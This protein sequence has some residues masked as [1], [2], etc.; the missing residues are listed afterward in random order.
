MRSLKSSLFLALLLAP[1]PLFAD[2][3]NWRGPTYDGVA[4]EKGVLPK[5]VVG[6]RVAWKKSLGTGYSSVAIASGKAVT[7]FGDGTNDYVVA[8]DLASGREL[9]RYRADLTYKGGLAGSGS[10]DGASGTPSIEGGVV[11]ALA[12]MGQLLALDLATGKLL[13]SRRVDQEDAAKPPGA[14]F[15]TSPTIAG[16]IVVVQTGGAAGHG[17]TGYDKL[18]GARLWSRG[19]DPVGYQSP[20]LATIDGKRQLVALSQRELA[21][22]DPQTG[23]V[24]WQQVFER[25][26]EDGAMSHAI[27]AGA[28]TILLNTRNLGTSLLRV[29]KAGASTHISTAVDAKNARSGNFTLYLSKANAII[30]NRM[31]PVPRPPSTAIR[32]PTPASIQSA[33]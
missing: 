15:V 22:L 8:L 31:I 6:L 20:I 3:P 33:S 28:D 10:A 5:D 32:A 14:G 30:P 13:W 12:P 11:Y 21:G 7:F 27:P 24:F 4:V 23:T 9:W 29:I 1:V 19:D 17:L 26:G 2:W 25:K 18:T 16:G